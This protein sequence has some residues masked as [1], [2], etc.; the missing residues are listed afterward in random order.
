MGASLRRARHFVV[1]A[2]YH[3]AGDSR[4]SEQLRIE[5]LQAGAQQPLL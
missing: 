5:L 3:P 1:A 4:L 2:D